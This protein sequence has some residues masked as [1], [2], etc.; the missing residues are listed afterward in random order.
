[1]HQCLQ[2][3]EIVSLICSNLDDQ[4]T[5]APQRRAARNLLDLSALARTCMMFREPALDTLWREQDSLAPFLNLMPDDLFESSNG[6]L[7]DRR[8]VSHTVWHLR[9][10][11]PHLTCPPVQR[12]SRPIVATDWNRAPVYTSRVKEL[13][14]PLWNFQRISDILPAFNL[15][16]PNGFLFPNLRIA[17]F[18]L[19]HSAPIRI[20]LPATL[21]K[22]SLSCEPSHISI[23]LLSAIPNLCPGLKDVSVTSWGKSDHVHRSISL[24]ICALHGLV[25]LTTTPPIWL[26]YPM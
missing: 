19:F 3:V 21:E 9:I 18:P 17:R 24:L 6:R 8:W 12:L 10:I 11:P 2:I 22:I 20:F 13:F 7:Y 14:L 16:C 26:S 5:L 15:C 23:S 1:M 4:F 25:S